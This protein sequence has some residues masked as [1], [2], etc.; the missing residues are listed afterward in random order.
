[1]QKIWILWQNTNMHYNNICWSKVGYFIFFQMLGDR[2]WFTFSP[3]L[4]HTRSMRRIW[5]EFDV[6]SPRSVSSK[7]SFVMIS[8]PTPSGILPG[9]AYPTNHVTLSRYAT[10]YSADF[11]R[12]FVTFQWM[13]GR[14]N[15][16][17]LNRIISRHHH[18]NTHTSWVIARLA[19]SV[20][21]NRDVKG[22][23]DFKR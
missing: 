11:G 3:S 21:K 23:G 8:P 16:S 4:N 18:T 9:A 22:D 15:L 6:N 1:M 12:V 7:F 17:G 10:R 13:F 5:A 2:S 20:H 19:I 14:R